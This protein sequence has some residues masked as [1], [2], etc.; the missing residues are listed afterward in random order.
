[1]KSGHV[2]EQENQH[3]RLMKGGMREATSSST[4]AVGQIPVKTGQGDEDGTNDTFQAP[5]W[6]SH[7]L[8]FFDVCIPRDLYAFFDC[9]IS[10][11]LLSVNGKSPLRFLSCAWR[12]LELIPDTDLGDL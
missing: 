12:D 9:L 3:I 8:R 4:T 2:W 5:E 10:R 1:V 11:T 6:M 7:C